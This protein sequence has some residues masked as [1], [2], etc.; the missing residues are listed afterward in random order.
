MLLDNSLIMK[1]Q[2]HHCQEKNVNTKVVKYLWGFKILG[3]LYATFRFFLLG[4]N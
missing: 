4:V 2:N 1:N 3:A